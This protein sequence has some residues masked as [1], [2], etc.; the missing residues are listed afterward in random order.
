MHSAT[1]TSDIIEENG[2]YVLY[3]T[4][5]TN[6]IVNIVILIPVREEHVGC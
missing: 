3:Y 1:I 6:L 2:Q 5:I 4:Y